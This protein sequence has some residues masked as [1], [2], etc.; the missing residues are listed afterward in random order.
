[1]TKYHHDPKTAAG[2]PLT[3]KDLAIFIPTMTTALALSWQVGRLQ[4][5]GGF[6]YFSLSDHLVASAAFF[7]V[8]LAIAA[9]FTVAVIFISNPPF[10]SPRSSPSADCLFLPSFLPCC[11]TGR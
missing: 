7:P 1:M 2:E 5:T 8:A 6:F 9:F 3:I 11:C 10:L 4:P